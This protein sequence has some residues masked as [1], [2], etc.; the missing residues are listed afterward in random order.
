MSTT[1]MMM[2]L[3]PADGGVVWHHDL[4]AFEC[5]ACEEKIAVISR[6]V[7]LNPERLAI[8]R[9]LMVLDHAECWQY[10]DARMARMQRRFRREVKRQM[11]LEKR[12]GAVA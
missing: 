5:L 7:W 8:F 9:E 11:K 2:R 10:C 12:K 6:A 4:N 1:P 3:R